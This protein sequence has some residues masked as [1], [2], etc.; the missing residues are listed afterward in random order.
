MASLEPDFHGIAPG[1]TFDVN[2]LDEIVVVC[3]I[4][5]RP[6]YSSCHGL[7]SRLGT[8]FD[9]PFSVLVVLDVDL[10]LGALVISGNVTEFSSQV[11]G[12]FATAGTVKKIETL[13]VSRLVPQD[14]VTFA[15]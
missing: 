9:G 2:S 10:F 4:A 5:R 12:A 11:R 8:E 6:H 3:V 14:R 1:H 13:N 15:G 7:R